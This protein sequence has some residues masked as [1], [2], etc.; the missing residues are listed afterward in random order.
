MDNKW[1]Y[2]IVGVVAGMI[3]YKL[4]SPLLAKVGLAYEQSFEEYKENFPHIK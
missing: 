1:V 3:V 2:I 4:A